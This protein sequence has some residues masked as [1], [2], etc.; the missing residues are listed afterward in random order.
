VALGDIKEGGKAITLSEMTR[1]N[2]GCPKCFPS[3]K[4]FI[5]VIA[6]VMTVLNK[7]QHVGH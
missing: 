7:Q 4:R 5:V 3:I 1:K 2:G 6:V